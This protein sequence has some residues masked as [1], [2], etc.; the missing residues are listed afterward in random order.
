MFNFDCFNFVYMFK[1]FYCRASLS[2]TNGKYAMKLE[3]RQKAVSHQDGNTHLA[4][5]ENLLQAQADC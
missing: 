5:E 2:P 4:C 1:V 3:T